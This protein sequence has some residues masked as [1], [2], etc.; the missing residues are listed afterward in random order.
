[1]SLRTPTQRPLVI[2]APYTMVARFED[3]GR[4]S[5]GSDGQVGGTSSRIRV[6][7]VRP[8]NFLGTHPRATPWPVDFQELPPLIVRIDQPNHLDT[9][10]TQDQ[11]PFPRRLNIHPL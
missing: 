4:G 11:S 3:H 1:M 8:P 5:M 7:Q 10:F 6:R 9:F 2:K